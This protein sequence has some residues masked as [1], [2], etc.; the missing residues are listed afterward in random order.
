MRAQKSKPDRRLISILT[1]ADETLDNSVFDSIIE[2]GRETIPDLIAI[3]ENDTLGSANARGRGYAPIHAVELLQELHAV[4]ACEP[5]LRLLLR[6]DEMEIIYGCLVRAL[7]FFGP[8]ILEQT[9]KAY[10]DAKNDDEREKIAN[11]LAGLKVTDGKILKILLR[12]LEQNEELGASL[13]AKY[14]D[15]S[16]LPSLSAKLDECRVD[17]DG[18]IFAN[19]EIIELTAA[20]EELGGM[21]TE[22]QKMLRQNA[23]K[24][25]NSFAGHFLIEAAVK[26]QIHAQNNAR[27]HWSVNQD[28]A[29]FQFATTLTLN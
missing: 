22:S 5:M 2:R 20:I 13:L 14:G 10:S 24:Q 28:K 12:I 19:Q 7:E 29:P 17:P 21:L 25:G 11:V 27:L 15:P 8:Q 6:C 18:G 3:M 23:T 16:A 26:Q 4:E 1:K 9:L